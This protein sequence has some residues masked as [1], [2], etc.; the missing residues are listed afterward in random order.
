MVLFARSRALSPPRPS[1][2]SENV[3]DSRDP[4]A[5]IETLE[6]EVH[7]PPKS[8]VPK[9][10]ELLRCSRS[11]LSEKTSNRGAIS[12]SNAALP[13]DAELNCALEFIAAELDRALEFIGAELDC[14]LEFFDETMP[15]DV[16]FRPP[17]P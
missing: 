17:K 10:L 2:S 12:S 11:S 1:S 5:E 9:D 4:P 6:V 8:P 16:H 14:A 13:F 3:R 15:L 7:S